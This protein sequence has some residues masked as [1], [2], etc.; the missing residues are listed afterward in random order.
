[1]L[2]AASLCLSHSCKITEPG[3]PSCPHSRPRFATRPFCSLLSSPLRP[4]CLPNSRAGE[5]KDPRSPRRREAFAGCRNRVRSGVQTGDLVGADGVGRRLAFGARVRVGNGH[6]RT[7][8]HGS[9]VVAD[10]TLERALCL[11]EER[12]RD[13]QGRAQQQSVFHLLSHTQIAD[14]A[15]SRAA[16]VY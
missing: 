8:N 6:D 13:E 10:D 3:R 7:R 4:N 2:V 14:S 11:R 5:T 9:G 1:M 12:R 16:K 15:K